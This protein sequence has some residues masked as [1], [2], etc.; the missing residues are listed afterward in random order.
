MLVNYD[1]SLSPHHSL[2]G[3]FHQNIGDPKSQEC[4]ECAKTKSPSGDL[5]IKIEVKGRMEV[6][7]FR[8]L[9]SCCNLTKKPVPF[10]QRL[11]R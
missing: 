10:K 2:T 5:G 11:S 4:K 9:G 8:S 1:Y 3:E 7:R 6:T